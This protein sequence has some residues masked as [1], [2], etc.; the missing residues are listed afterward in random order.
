MNAKKTYTVAALA[1]LAILGSFLTGV[2]TTSAQP[3]PT[4]PSTPEASSATDQFV[5]LASALNAQA[6]W[7]KAVIGADGTTSAADTPHCGTSGECNY[8]VC[9][10]SSCPDGYT[11]SCSCTASGD[12]CG[13]FT[14]Y[15]VYN[16]ECSC[17]ATPSNP[18]P[19]DP[20]CQVKVKEVCVLLQELTTS[21][22]EPPSLRDL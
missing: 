17:K 19:Q 9:P 11:E 15:P 2:G 20:P 22:G 10:A 1:A 6:E 18:P 4:N 7:A 5:T 8:V 16:C 14:K 21:G 12:S 3:D 13:F